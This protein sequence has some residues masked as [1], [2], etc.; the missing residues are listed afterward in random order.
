MTPAQFLQVGTIRDIGLDQSNVG[1]HQQRT[2]SMRAPTGYGYLP[3]AI[4]QSKGEVGT[5]KPATPED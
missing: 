2:V 3:A 1:M 4:G 5:D